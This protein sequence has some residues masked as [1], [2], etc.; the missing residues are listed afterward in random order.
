[1]PR[2]TI[3]HFRI[4]PGEETVGGSHRDCLTDAFLDGAA[5]GLG[6]SADARRLLDGLHPDEARRYVERVRREAEITA[7]EAER[8]TQYLAMRASA[9]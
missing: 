3:C 8:F 6:I 1:M 4:G 7:R 2:C 9:R 5:K